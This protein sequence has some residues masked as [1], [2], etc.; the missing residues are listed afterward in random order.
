MLTEVEVRFNAAVQG[1]TTF[2]NNENN[3]QAIAIG[4]YYIEGIRVKMSTV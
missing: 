3:K 1:K 2:A 4:H